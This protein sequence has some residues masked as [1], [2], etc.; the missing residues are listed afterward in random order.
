MFKLHDATT[1]KCGLTVNT[2]TLYSLF[3][4]NYS[5][6][7]CYSMQKHEKIKHVSWHWQKLPSHRRVRKH[8]PMPLNL[9]NRLTRHV[10]IQGTSVNAP[11]T[12]M[13]QFIC[14][15]TDM[16]STISYSFGSMTV[17]TSIIFD[18]C[19]LLLLLS[20]IFLKMPGWCSPRLT[21]AF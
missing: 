5:G 9:F 12:M 2:C 14:C 18:L 16:F 21:G 10:S 20:C 8:F 15:F 11:N 7:Y 19:I 13:V 3:A 17:I 1:I 6:Y 4:Y